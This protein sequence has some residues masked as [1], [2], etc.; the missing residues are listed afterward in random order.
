MK[1]ITLTFTEISIIRVTL[2]SKDPNA[3]EV[4][5][6]NR[7]GYTIGLVDREDY[8]HYDYPRYKNF[9]SEFKINRN[10]I[11]SFKEIFKL[12]FISE[13]SFAS[14]FIPYLKV[15]FIHADKNHATQLRRL[16]LCN[17]DLAFLPDRYYI[18]PLGYVE[19]N[20]FDYVK[21]LFPNENLDLLDENAED[22]EDSNLRCYIFYC[23]LLSQILFENIRWGRYL[24]N[25]LLDHPHYLG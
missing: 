3:Q 7:S 10:Y 22:R 13:Y 2:K 24:Y 16:I 5:F 12:N 14:E 23:A 11:V 25:I 20:E 19:D 1:N 18:S 15:L 8:E 21:P 17:L 4:S 6:P 9:R